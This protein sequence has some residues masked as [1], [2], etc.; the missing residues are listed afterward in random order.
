MATFNN[1]LNKLNVEFHNPGYQYCGPG[2]K[3]AK[4]IA[5][6]DPGINKLDKF[7]KE[8]DLIYSKN[9]DDLYA[10]READKFLT[11]RQ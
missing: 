4:R 9:R 5:R 2:T 11:K 10:R 3:L 1:L 7:C 6:G 8:H